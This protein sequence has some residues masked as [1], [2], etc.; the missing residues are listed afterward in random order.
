MGT[1][2]HSVWSR[3]ILPISDWKLENPIC[4]VITF[5]TY[6]AQSG[7]FSEAIESHCGKLRKSPAEAESKPTVWREGNKFTTAALP[8]LI[9]NKAVKTCL[10]I[11]SKASVSSKG[12]AQLSCP[13]WW[14][15]WASVATFSGSQNWDS[16]QR[17]YKTMSE[18]R[19]LEVQAFVK[20]VSIHSETHIRIHTTN[21]C[22][23]RHIMMKCFHFSDK[24][25]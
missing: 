15:L 24:Q 19:S 8:K 12:G 20:Q 13:S 3:L 18:R 22:Q 10:G 11:D 7:G 2:H 4:F 14:N 1:E 5:C 9:L 23:K 25:Q 21:C 16:L 6:T 17:T